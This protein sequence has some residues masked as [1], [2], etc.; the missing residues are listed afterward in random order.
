MS[1]TISKVIGLKKTAI[2]PYINSTLQENNDDKN[3]FSTKKLKYLEL[4]I[5]DFEA[6]KRAIDSNFVQRVEELK[7]Y[8]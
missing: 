2:Q 1:D 8:L 7:P 5:K 4:I 6:G 3:I